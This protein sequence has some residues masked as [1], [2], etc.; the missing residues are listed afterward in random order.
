MLQKFY[1]LNVPPQFEKRLHKR[2]FPIALKNPRRV[3]LH[4][5]INKSVSEKFKISKFVTANIA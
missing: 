5:Y 1:N 2:P 4:Q 3:L